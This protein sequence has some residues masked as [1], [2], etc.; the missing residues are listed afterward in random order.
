[1]EVW[2]RDHSQV[3]RICSLK[4]TADRWVLLLAFLAVTTKLPAKAVSLCSQI[5]SHYVTK[6]TL[7]V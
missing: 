3:A 4:S 1:M 2:S 5:R 6:N 7:N